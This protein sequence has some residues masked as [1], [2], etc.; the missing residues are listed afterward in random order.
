VLLDAYGVL[1]IGEGPVPGAVA[2]VA[3]LRDAGKRVMV[4]TNS[5]GYPKRVMMERYARL[6]YD[7]APDEVTSSR[8]ALLDRL[9]GDGRRWGLMLG[10]AHGSEDLDRLLVEFLAENA[11]AYRRA[12]GFLLIGSEGWTGTR[13]ALLEAAL[14]E[15]P[16]PVLV[17]K[18]DLV[19]PREGGL[20]LEPGHF[21][22]RLADRTGISPEFLGKPFPEIFRRAMARLPT[23][24]LPERVLMVGDTLH[25]DMLG[26]RNMGYATALLT[27]YGSQAGADAA[28]A[29]ASSAIV[30]DFVSS[31][32]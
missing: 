11:A 23:K 27:G 5:A 31:R 1:N 4:V 13:Q 6:G 3:R 16:R 14:R 22:H 20:T 28:R 24:H 32:L 19:A 2:F 18:P 8:E 10:S 29:I 25:T 15:R 26:G 12:D 7:F 21:A 9:A 30:P 17:G